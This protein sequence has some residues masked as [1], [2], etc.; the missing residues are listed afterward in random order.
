MLY[1]IYKLFCKDPEI[2]HVYVGSTKCM[3]SRMT[4]HKTACVNPNNTHYDYKIY[5]F[6][7]D[8]GGWDNWSY[9][10]LEMVEADNKHGVRDREQYYCDTLNAELNKW[11][12]LRTLDEATK[13]YKKGTEWYDKNKKR[14]SERYHKQ[15]EELIK[16]REEVKTLTIKEEVLTEMN[17]QLKN[18]LEELQNK[19][20]GIHKALEITK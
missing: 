20:D 16:L 7:R 9:E 4:S 10:I 12:A 18:K 11:K 14:A 17:E 1:Y 5:K 13:Y 3:S 19:L 8:N 15:Q 2:T 6:I